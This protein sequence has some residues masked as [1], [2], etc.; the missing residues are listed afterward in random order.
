MQDH[1]THTWQPR[2]TVCASDTSELG[3]KNK[4]LYELLHLQFLGAQVSGSWEV[5]SCLLG[6]LS[7]FLRRKWCLLPEQGQ[8]LHLAFQLAPG[9]LL[10]TL[11]SYKVL[12]HYIFLT[13]LPPPWPFLDGI[14][15]FF[16]FNVYSWSAWQVG[17]T[18]SFCQSIVHLF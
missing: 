13:F 7:T 6:G 5:P 17:E 9:Q 4:Q 16:K 3:G 2:S 11:F 18:M 12:K 14:W 1:R 8:I 10:Y 15:E